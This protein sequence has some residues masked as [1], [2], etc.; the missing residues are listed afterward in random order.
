MDKTGFLRLFAVTLEYCGNC[1][2]ITLGPERPTFFLILGVFMADIGAI[3]N[4]YLQKRPEFTVCGVNLPP[5]TVF[6]KFFAGILDYCEN[7]L[8][9]TLGPERPT[10]C[11]IL[12]FGKIC[13]HKL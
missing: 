4:S 2:G 10:F 7:R 13:L 5:Q 3:F 1:L 9:I 12:R 11:L 8:G 6:F